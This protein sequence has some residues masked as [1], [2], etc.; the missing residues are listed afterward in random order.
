MINLLP[1]DAKESVLYARRNTLL[2]RWLAAIIVGLIGV[3]ITVAAGQYYLNQ[4][5]KSYATDVEKTQQLL[6]DQQLDETQ[7]RVTEISS[8]M[9]LMVDVLSRQ[10]L[11]SDLIR[12]VGAAIPP[13]AALTNLSINKLE[14]GIDLQF[15]ATDYQTST[16]V[17]VNL[18]DP[19]NRIFEKADLININCQSPTGDETPSDL[20]DIKY[21]CTVDI[22]ALFA[23]DNPFLFISKDR[24]GAQ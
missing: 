7:K 23:K 3:V 12:Q 10:V 11:F 20:I 14:G 24:V 13:G 5:A 9:K 1:P 8:S 17:Q 2:V 22:R 16:Q 18:E 21:P 19:D 15:K 4:S 6:K